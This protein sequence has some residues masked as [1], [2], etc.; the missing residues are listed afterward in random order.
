MTSLLWDY[1]DGGFAAYGKEVFV[2]HYA[3][4]SKAAA[5]SKELLEYKIEKGWKLLCIFLGCRVLDM[6]FPSGNTKARLICIS[7]GWFGRGLVG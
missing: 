7:R 5:E 3:Q 6:L 1:F 2:R 4:V